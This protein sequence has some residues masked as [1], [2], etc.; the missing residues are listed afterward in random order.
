VSFE[1]VSF[2]YP[3]STD[4][5]LNEISFHVGAGERVALV[6]VN[7]AGKTTLVKLLSRLYDPVS[8]RICVDGVDLREMDPAQW[9]RQIG[10]IF[11]D[12]TRYA[13]TARENV[14]FGQISSV[15]DT[16]RIRAAAALSGATACIERLEKGW[17]SVLGKTFDEGHELSVGEWQKVALARAFMR[18]AQILVLDEPTASL[19]AKQ[20]Y[21][22]FCRFNEIT[23]SKTTFLISH[24]FSTVRMADR[25]FV[26]DQGRLVESGNH[27]ELMAVRGIYADL[28]SRQAA[29]YASAPTTPGMDR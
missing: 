25:I 16:T 24:R 13:F 28:F 7:G 10:V 2:R 4:L 22:T 29:G 12:F 8:G 20:E 17:D 23:G 3:G 19:D 14:G 9:H 11:Q 1:S 5:A 27:A 15:D 6:G 18:D 21:E 26:I